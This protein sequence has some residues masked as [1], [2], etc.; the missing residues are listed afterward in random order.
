MT[1]LSMRAPE[2]DLHGAFHHA[3]ALFH[4]TTAMERFENQHHAAATP[5]LI[6]PPARMRQMPMH[7][8]FGRFAPLR[9][10][11]SK[12]WHADCRISIDL[13]NSK[14]GFHMDKTAKGTEE[15]KQIISFTAGAEEYGLELLR[16]REVIRMRPITRLPR[17]PSCVM[18][19]VNLRG[20][21]IPIVDLRARF[22]LAR[23]EHTAMTRII[24]VKVDQK[25]VGMVVDSTSQVVRLPTDQISPPPPVV[26]QAVQDFITGVAKL[27]EKL[28]ILIDVDK[29]LSASEMNQIDHSVRAAKEPAV[30]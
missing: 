14:R 30:A 23:I 27:D 6:A 29:I 20:D 7:Y 9:L 17:A 3:S 11:A 1:A 18:G 13:F 22:G 26:G 16:V 25:P 28:I 19:I 4:C 2:S 10:T 15:M 24:V 5:A 21:V 8:G 12:I